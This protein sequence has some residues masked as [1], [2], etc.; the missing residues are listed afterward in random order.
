VRKVAEFFGL[1]YWT[2][3]GQIVHALVTA[4][5]GRDGKVSKLYPGNDWHPAGVLVDLKAVLRR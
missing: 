1:Q 3:S 2:D 4:L 5:I